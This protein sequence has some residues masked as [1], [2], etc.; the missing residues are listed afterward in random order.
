MN[1]PAGIVKVYV[2]AASGATSCWL[3][4]VQPSPGAARPPRAVMEVG[5]LD[6]IDEQVVPGD[7]V[8]S[9]MKPPA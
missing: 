5:P 2:P 8:V 9:E 3:T 6:T 7:V 4:T 1:P